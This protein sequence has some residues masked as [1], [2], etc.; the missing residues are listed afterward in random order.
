[1]WRSRAACTGMRC[2]ARCSAKGACTSRRTDPAVPAAARYPAR[3]MSSAQAEQPPDDGPTVPG[4]GRR[5]SG[6]ALPD[7]SRLR[8]FEIRSVVGEGGF[9]IVYLAW[10]GSLERQVAIKE[11]MPATLASRTRT[12]FVSPLSEKLADTFALGLRSFV[13]EAHL[14]A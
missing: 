6:N 3:A 2:A 13:N 10:D 14:L 11:Y 5:R 1:M 4:P 9:G 12:T 7:G 8:E